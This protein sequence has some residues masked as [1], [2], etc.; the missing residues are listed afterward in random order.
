MHNIVIQYF[1]TLQNDLH[2]KSNYHLPPLQSYYNII[3][4]IPHAII[5]SPWLIYFVAGSL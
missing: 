5:S 3:G 2:D 1:Y 4:Y